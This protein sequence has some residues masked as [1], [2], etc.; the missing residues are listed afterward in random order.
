[1]WI[2]CSASLCSFLVSHT[3]NYLGLR[4][5]SP[6]MVSQLN[7]LTRSHRIMLCD[8]SRDCDSEKMTTLHYIIS[9][10]YHVKILL[11]FFV[12]I[13]L[14]K[15]HIE[16]LNKQTVLIG[17]VCCSR[18]FIY[19]SLENHFDFFLLISNIFLK[20]LSITVL[21]LVSGYCTTAQ[22]SSPI[23]GGVL[24]LKLYFAVVLLLFNGFPVLPLK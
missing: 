22:Y 6:S 17:L 10:S 4:W 2:S 20:K 19:W 15:D 9:Q 8:E 14:S 11:T 18:V 23:P 24:L 7:S 5:L 16:T 12:E 21:H 3:Q 1:M 13:V